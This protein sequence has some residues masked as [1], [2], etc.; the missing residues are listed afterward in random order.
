MGVLQVGF[1]LYATVLPV[2]L[3]FAWIVVALTDL[4][5]RDDLA[6]GGRLGWS[7]VVVLLPAIGAAGYLLGP[8][9][10]ARERALILVVGA[11]VAYLVVLAITVAVGG[12]A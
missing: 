2:A 1:S 3:A 5:R 4:L 11:V 7:A 9:R 8:A 12:T 6:G 10:L